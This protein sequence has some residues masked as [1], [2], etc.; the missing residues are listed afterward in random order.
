MHM[1]MPVAADENIV[2]ALRSMDAASLA[3]DKLEENIADD[4]FLPDEKTD[5][6]RASSSSFRTSPA[7]EFAY[8][9]IHDQSYPPTSDAHHS[10]APSV[11]DYFDPNLDVDASWFG[12][13]LQ[14]LA[15]ARVVASPRL[16]Q[17]KLPLMRPPQ[18]TTRRT[19]KCAPPSQTLTTQT[20]PC[21]R[22]A[23]GSSAY[24]GRWSSPG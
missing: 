4:L 21:P 8:P 13:S 17:P 11:S 9:D 1:S 2:D 6:I 24:S 12:E 7:T 14:F 15:A 19:Q 22:Y 5:S 23:H 20:C 10:T 18:R 16:A 3:E